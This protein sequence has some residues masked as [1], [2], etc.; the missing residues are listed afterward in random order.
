MEVGSL[1]AGNVRGGNF[2][3]FRTDGSIRFVGGATQFDDMICQAFGQN[4]DTSS[5][6]I[7]FD[8]AEGTVNYATN[9]RYP[10]EALFHPFQM[11]H[12]QME[13][14]NVY[15]HVHWL[16]EENNIP[17]WLLRY[18]TWENGQTAGAYTN[19][20][21]TDNVFT[22]TSGTILQITTFPAFA[23]AS[24]VSN[25]V[26]CILYRDT[27]NDSGLFAGS[28]PYTGLA[29]LKFADLHYEIDSTGSF[30]EYSKEM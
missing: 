26:D 18:R 11:S 16:Q 8:Y 20:E 25:C 9:S 14:S 7:D 6:R 5:G 3:E 2:T 13:S 1:K 24:G 17:N 10:N 12:K 28:D 21:Y 22:Y 27:D 19:V 29:K 23:S 4:I 30:S 15:F